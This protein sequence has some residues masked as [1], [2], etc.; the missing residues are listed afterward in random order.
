MKLLIDTE[1]ESLTVVEGTIED[2]RGFAN[3]CEFKFYEVIQKEHNPITDLYLLPNP[4]SD[5]PNVDLTKGNKY[6]LEFNGRSPTVSH[7]DA[8]LY[9]EIDGYGYCFSKGLTCDPTKRV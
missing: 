7:I 1:N 6:T 9:T 5:S 2:A 4:D 8:H 3:S